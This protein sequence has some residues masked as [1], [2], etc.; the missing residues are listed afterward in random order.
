M[1][2]IN[3]AAIPDKYNEQEIETLQQ[4]IIERIEQVKFAEKISERYSENILYPLPRDEP[5]LYKPLDYMNFYQKLTHN[6]DE[7]EIKKY[8][9]DK[10]KRILIK[11]D[12]QINEDG[13][14][15]GSGKNRYFMRIDDKDE[16]NKVVLDITN[17]DEDEEYK[18]VTTQLGIPIENQSIKDSC[19]K[20][21]DIDYKKILE[22]KSKNFNISDS[23]TKSELEIY[24]NNLE[25][26]AIDNIS[27]YNNLAKKILD[28]INDGKLLLLNGDTEITASGKPI[29]VIISDNYIENSFISY[30]EDIFALLDVDCE[31]SNEFILD[32]FACSLDEIIKAY[33]EGNIE[34]INNL[35]IDNEESVMSKYKDIKYFV[36]ENIF[37]YNLEDEDD[38]EHR[39]QR[40]ST[41]KIQE[42]KNWS[43][44]WKKNPK[45]ESD[46]KD[47][48]D[49]DFEEYTH[50]QDQKNEIYNHLIISGLDTGDVED[51][52]LQKIP[53]NISKISELLPTQIDKID[54]E[55]HGRDNIYNYELN[56]VLSINT[57]KYIKIMMKFIFLIK[58]NYNICES[59]PT[60]KATV[61]K[62]RLRSWEASK[63]EE[64]NTAELDLQNID[65]HN[66]YFEFY[67]YYLKNVE[68]EEGD[69]MEQII[70]GLRE[71]FSNDNFFNN[72]SKIFSILST[73]PVSPDRDYNELDINE[74][75]YTQ[76]YHRILL[77][78]IFYISIY[79]IIKH[80]NEQ[81]NDSLGILLEM[82]KNVIFKSIN[83]H[84]KFDIKTTLSVSN[85]LDEEKA[86]QNEYRKNKFNRKNHSEK[87]IHRL[88]RASNLGNILKDDL[89]LED[90]K[91]D[92]L[93]RVILEQEKAFFSGGNFS[94]GAAIEE[95][96]EN[97]FEMQGDLANVAGEDDH[98][99]F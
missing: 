33:N 49:F 75:L 10:I 20:K 12:I 19:G 51:I 29:S 58:N 87:N 30:L 42:A 40:Y 39:A 88:K 35:W 74:P 25:I 99:N 59:F 67:T 17:I 24:F 92:L 50:K 95:T 36:L 86:K 44:Y 43:I 15:T 84:Y 68:S 27:N 53:K 8:I 18:V 54:N 11:F 57:I 94:E 83:N 6:M 93:L 2:Y 26:N 16:F 73:I 22:D 66:E 14:I 80:I 41:N 45:E 72:Y 89:D 61:N 79:K 55:F 1:A 90:D 46:F 77:E 38:D 28:K 34:Q 63:E 70:A 98:D 3:F 37:G 60:S 91:P 69:P 13:S 64:G 85:R 4:D 48:L 62:D 78:S 32:D 21:N 7:Q 9:S 47:F 97:P 82:I 56:D 96:T 76:K 81:Y 5:I 52:Q 23:N 65:L 31:D 71:L